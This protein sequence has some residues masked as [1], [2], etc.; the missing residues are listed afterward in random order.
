MRRFN[1][2][3]G[4]M[5]KEEDGEYVLYSEIERVLPALIRQLNAILAYLE[6]LYGESTT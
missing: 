2:K 1:L 4:K 3:D 6:S 5:V